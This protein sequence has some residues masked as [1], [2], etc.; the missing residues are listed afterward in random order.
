[1][2]RLLAGV[3][4]TLYRDEW[5]NFGHNRSLAFAR[6]RGTADWLIASDADMTWDLGAFVPGDAEAYMVDMGGDGMSNR[7]PLILRGDFPWRS[8]GAVHEYTALDRLYVTATCDVRITQPGA[9]AWTREKGLWHLSMLEA[10]EHDPRTVFYLAKTLDELGDPRAKRTYEERVAMGGWE[11]E[12]YYAAWR[13]AAL[14]PDVYVRCQALLAAWEMRPVRLEALHDAIEGLNQTGR[15]HAAYLLSSLTTEPCDDSLFV[16][17]WIWDWGI[18]FQRQIAAWWVEAPEF[19]LITDRLR[20]L[21]LPPHIRSAVE[22]N[23]GLR[24]A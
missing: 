20:S 22:R 7:L 4:G 8:V 6:A 10:E 24:A 9:H 18:L 13:A 15:H 21:D 23:A 3:P 17:R 19:D 11:Q 5:V 12:V 16:H 14:E 1:V 2:E